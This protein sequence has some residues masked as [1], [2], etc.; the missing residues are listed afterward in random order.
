[1]TTVGL[2]D[3]SVLRMILRG[4][5]P[6]IAQAECAGAD[7]ETFYPGRGESTLKAKAVCNGCPV[8]TDCLDWALKNNEREGVWG[9]TS[10]RERKAMRR[11]LRLAS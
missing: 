9:G 11:T 5:M 6:W 3:D 7:P 8:R 1:M 10:E 4:P 2:S